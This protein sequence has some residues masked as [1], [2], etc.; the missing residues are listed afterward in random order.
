MLLKLRRD[1]RIVSSSF[2]TVEF[3]CTIHTCCGQPLSMA[4]EA[5]A[6]CCCCVVVEHLQLCP[7]LAQVN[8][9][10]VRVSKSLFKAAKFLLP[11]VSSSNG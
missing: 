4:S 3:Q 6:G 11:Y 7:L 9:E 1:L 5:N 8:S 2:D 10:I